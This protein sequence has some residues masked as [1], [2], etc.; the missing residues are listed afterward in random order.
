MRTTEIEGQR[1]VL[2]A[3]LAIEKGVGRSTINNAIKDER[4]KGVL[5]FGRMFV[6]LSEAEAFTVQQRGGNRGGGRKKKPATD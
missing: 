1:Y 2:V 4:L 5:L 3:D 6:P